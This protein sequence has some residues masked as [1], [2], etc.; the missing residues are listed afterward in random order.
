MPL[1]PCPR[2]ARTVNDRVPRCPWC[3]ADVVPAAAA[4]PGAYPGAAVPYPPAW[5]EAGGT[6]QPGHSYTPPGNPVSPAMRVGQVLAVLFCVAGGFLAADWGAGSGGSHAAAEALGKAIGASIAPFL[7]SALF[8]AWSRST[9]R[10][11]PFLAA[12]F[13]ML[14][15]AGRVGTGTSMGSGSGREEVDRELAR[16]RGMVTAFADSGGGVGD[17]PASA[18][19]AG[20]K[21]KLVWAMNRAL[22][23]APSHMREVAGR[24]RVD[25]DV[26]PAAWGT[27]RYMADAGSHPEVG[28]YWLAYQAYLADFRESFPGWLHSRVE[29][30]GRE[31]GVRSRLL[32]SFLEGMDRGSAAIEFSQPLALADSTATAALAYH[33]FLVSVDARASYDAAQD[34]AVFDREADL[35]RADA[36]Q[37]RVTNMAELLNRA[38]R[39]AQRRS[40]QQVNSLAEQFR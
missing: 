35:Q 1:R 3:G 27:S 26:L 19:P 34:V 40:M 15:A 13:V 29:A 12:A 24:H 32:R 5:T 10:Y 30:H 6:V 28:R 16:T 36:L 14:S 38:Q 20:Q 21:A 8:L 23:E 37:A 11:I 9:R 39:G 25:P 17:A 22:A 4:W 7:L 2:C 18:P 31:A 33:R